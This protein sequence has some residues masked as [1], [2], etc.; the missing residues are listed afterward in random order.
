MVLLAT[1]CTGASWG[2]GKGL[3]RYGVQVFTAEVSH[4]LGHCLTCHHCFSEIS[5]CEHVA[6]TAGFMLL[7]L[8]GVQAL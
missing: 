5:P 6:L 2:W 3:V 1:L 4:G 8:A 7:R